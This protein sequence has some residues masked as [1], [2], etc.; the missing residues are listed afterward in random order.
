VRSRQRPAKPSGRSRGRLRTAKPCG[1]GTRCWCQA[2]GGASTQ[3]GPNNPSIRRR[4]RQ[5][6]TR[7]RGE[8]GI[9]RKTIA[10]GMSDALRCPVCSC[11]SHHSFAHET[12][13]AARTRHSLR[14]LS[15]RGAD[16]SVKLR[17][18]RAARLWSRIQVVTTSLRAQRSNLLSPGTQKDGLLRCARNDGLLIRNNS[19]QTGSCE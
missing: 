9:S 14:P 4:R 10:Q 12:A 15:S 7:L 11:A 16:I 3:P 5:K 18:P 1:P 8:L 2:G 13:G 17:A 19:Q 6:R